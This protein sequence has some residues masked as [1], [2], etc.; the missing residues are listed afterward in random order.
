[1][2][3]NVY[4]T[5]PSL[6]FHLTLSPSAY[7]YPCNLLVSD[8]GIDLRAGNRRM[9]HHLGYALNWNTCLQGQHAEAVATDIVG[10]EHECHTPNPRLF[11]FSLLS[12]AFHNL[13]PFPLIAPA[14]S[15][16]L[17]SPRF[18]KPPLSY[19]ILPQTSPPFP[20]SSSNLPFR[21]VIFFCYLC[22]A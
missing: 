15:F 17:V 14:L 3:E 11:P 5:F 7:P 4:V 18:S 21:R 9:P 22:G 20:L 8:L 19:P 1:M 12:R 16:L 6:V 2:K 13:I 10:Q